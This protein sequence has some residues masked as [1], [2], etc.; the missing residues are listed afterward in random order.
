MTTLRGRSDPWLKSYLGTQVGPTPWFRFASLIGSRPRD[1]STLLAATPRG[2]PC[3]RGGVS[4]PAPGGRRDGQ[5]PLSKGGVGGGKL[6]GSLG[7][8]SPQRPAVGDGC[9]TAEPYPPP[10]RPPIYQSRPACEAAVHG[11]GAS[12]GLAVARSN[13][14]LTLRAVRRVFPRGAPLGAPLGFSGTCRIGLSLSTLLSLRC[15]AGG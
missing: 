13:P 7:S 3:S 6:L 9:P 1:C 4:G 15:E 12:G 14:D 8:R 11:V 10:L 5:R 2:R